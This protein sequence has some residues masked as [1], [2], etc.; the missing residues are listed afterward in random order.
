VVNRFEAVV[1]ESSVVVSIEPLMPHA[2][3]LRIPVTDSTPVERFL[4]QVYFG[5]AST[6]EPFTYGQAWMLVDDEGR[7]YLDLGSN[8]S[9]AHGVIY[10]NRPIRDVGIRPGSHLTAISRG[11]QTRQSNNRR[12]RAETQSPQR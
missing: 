9:E 4:D 7:K 3:P 10:D 11:S 8:W 2:D 5:L 12:R 1:D 6:V